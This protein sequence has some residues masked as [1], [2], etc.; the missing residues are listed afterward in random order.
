M[1]EAQAPAREAYRR[2]GY[3]ALPGYFPRAL[4]EAFYSRVVAELDLTRAARNYAAHGP[5][6]TKTAIEVYS[7]IY[8]AMSGFLWGLTPAMEAIAGCRLL[9]TYCYFR[10]YQK[11]DLCKVH[12]DRH[13]CEHSLSLTMAVSDEQPWALGVGKERLDGPTKSITE[14]FGEEAFGSVSMMPGDAVAYQGV[15]HRH[16]RTDPNPNRWSAHLFL[17][18]VDAEGPYRNQAF[19]KPALDAARAGSR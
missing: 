4:T 13:A 11:D 3:A 19:D 8:P 10:I 12:S 9:P 7:H 2:D 15:H 5:L 6:L 18:W 17:H 14:D 1:T 16:G